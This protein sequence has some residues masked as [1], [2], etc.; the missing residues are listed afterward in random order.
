MISSFKEVTVSAGV[1]STV[2][3]GNETVIQGG[4]EKYVA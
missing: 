1:L 3:F 2:L 4:R